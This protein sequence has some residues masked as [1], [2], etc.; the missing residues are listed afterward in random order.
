[1]SWFDDQLHTLKTHTFTS[2]VKTILCV[3]RHSEPESLHL[4]AN[5][6]PYQPALRS[7]SS[8][9]VSLEPP[10]EHHRPELSSEKDF[11]TR[12]SLPKAQGYTVTH[13]RPDVA[14]LIQDAVAKTGHKQRVLVA[15]CGPEG[16]M[17][18]VRQATSPLIQWGG[19]GVELHCEQFGW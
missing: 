15:A 19:P 17:N 9:E 5:G 14:T 18:V 16:L 8:A 12:P 4:P 10:L 13:G 1:M 11:E 2:R 6:R 3:T 7:A